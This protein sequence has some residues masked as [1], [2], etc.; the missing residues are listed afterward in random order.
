MQKVTFIPP[1]R[2]PIVWAIIWLA[3]IFATYVSV[4]QRIISI[5]AAI[6][7]IKQPPA[8]VANNFL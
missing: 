6:Y 1:V 3:F 7:Q 2:K 8:R 5:K 4:R